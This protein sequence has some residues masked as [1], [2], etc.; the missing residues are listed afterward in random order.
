MDLSKVTKMLGTLQDCTQ[1]AFRTHKTIQRILPHERVGLRHSQSLLG[2]VTIWRNPLQACLCQWKQ[3]THSPFTALAISI[4][5]SKR[6]QEPQQLDKI[7]PEN[8]TTSN[9]QWVPWKAKIPKTPSNKPE[10]KVATP[11]HLNQ[12]ETCRQQKRT[13]HWMLSS[14]Q[15]VWSVRANLIATRSRNF[16]REPA[17]QWCSMKTLKANNLAMWMRKRRK[18]PMSLQGTSLKLSRST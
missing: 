2:S 12:S 15:W 17:L 10:T 14:H 5:Q 6:N 9:P 1:P 4:T 13:R 8:T 16:L 18:A 3:Q 7:K 11:L